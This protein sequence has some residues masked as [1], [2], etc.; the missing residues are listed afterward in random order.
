M[1]DSWMHQSVRIY[2]DSPVI[3]FEFTVGPIPI[4]YEL[5]YYVHVHYKSA[6]STISFEL[7]YISMEKERAVNIVSLF[8]LTH[9]DHLGKE[10]V[11]RFSTDLDTNKTWYT[12]AN[13]REMQKRM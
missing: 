9:S 7:G 11:S 1:F 12:D 5:E 2:H 13:G 10:I 6:E 3:E 4:E 8:V